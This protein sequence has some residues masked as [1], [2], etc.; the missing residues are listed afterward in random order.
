MAELRSSHR[1]NNSTISVIRSQE[2]KL[3]NANQTIRSCLYSI[4]CR[5]R[6]PGL[7]VWVCSREIN[8]RQTHQ[9][10]QYQC[11]RSSAMLGGLGWYLAAD[12]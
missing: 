11:G 3:F 12:I 6:I 1:I 5:D 4:V 10:Q 7:A 9:L 2:A 8:G